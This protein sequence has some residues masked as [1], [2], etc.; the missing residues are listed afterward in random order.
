MDPGYL[1]IGR[2]CS[3]A[4]IRPTQAERALRLPCVGPGRMVADQWSLER[5][6]PRKGAATVPQDT[7]AKT[8][9]PGSQKECTPSAP[10]TTPVSDECCHHSKHSAP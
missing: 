3:L 5:A 6:P 10:Q 2:H 1:M 4:I 8:V 9:K 7:M